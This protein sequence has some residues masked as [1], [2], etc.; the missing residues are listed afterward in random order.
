MSHSLTL[1]RSGE[2]VIFDLEWTAWE[3]SLARNWTGPGEY[4][5]VIQIGAVTLEAEAFQL[6]ADFSLLVRPLKN[7]VLSDYIQNLTGISTTKMELE[8]VPYSEALDVFARYLGDRPAFCNGADGAVLEENSRLQGITHPFPSRRFGN[9]RPLLSLATGLP[10]AEL[11]SSD[12]PI[13]LGLGP[14]IGSHTGDGDARAI[15]E[16]L[17]ALRA[18]GAL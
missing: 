12:L 17:R 11:V 18:R 10:A 13:L 1:P 16:A 4:R 5:E 14:R 8:G 6:V 2:V 15:G 7:P 9:L 3:G